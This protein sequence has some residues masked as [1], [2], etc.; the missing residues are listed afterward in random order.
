MDCELN[1]MAFPK[2]VFDLA[3]KHPGL[4]VFDIG[5][6][7][8][9]EDFYFTEFCAMRY[10]WD[11]IFSEMVMRD[12]GEPFVN[13]YFQDIVD[14]VDPIVNTYGASVRLFNLGGHMEG[15]DQSECN[16]VVKW[17]DAVDKN[18]F[19]YRV[20]KKGPDLV[21][22]GG[23]DLLGVATGASNVLE[24]AVSRAY[25]VVDGVTLESLYYRPQ[26]D[27]LSMAYKSSILNRYAAIKPFLREPEDGLDD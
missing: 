20:K 6:L 18:L 25:K 22:V 8:N 13:N 9:G 27:F 17:K 7:Y 5:L 1:L 23:L 14:G 11:G 26:F 19:L 21:T 10:G 12:D 16:L 2:I 15:V 4:A 24:T 3:K